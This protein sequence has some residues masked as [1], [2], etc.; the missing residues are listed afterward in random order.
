MKKI[1]VTFS[2][3]VLL[4]CTDENYAELNQ[5][6]KSPTE[7]PGSFLF[8]GATKSLFDQMG[9]TSVN[10]NVFRLFAQHWTET[11]Y[12]TETNYNIKNRDIPG[13]HW[14]EMYNDVL[15]DLKKAKETI[16]SDQ[17]LLPQ[18]KSNQL[19]IL[20]ILEIY[21]WQQLVDTFGNIPYTEALQGVENKTPKYDDAAT[22]YSDLL[23]RIAAAHGQLNTS[24][25]GFDNDFI[26]NN[27]IAKWKKIAASLRFKIAMRIADA[28]ATLSKSHA[29]AAFADGLIASNADN[30]TLSY[31]ANT[32]NAHPLYADLVMSGRQDF[33]PADTFV[34]YLNNL[35]DPRRAVFFDDNKTPYVGG[36]YGDFNN[37]AN[38]TH[39]GD[40]FFTPDLTGNIMDFS[41]ISF[42]LA[43]AK[44]RGYNV[45]L[46]AA[47]YYQQAVTASME[48]WG[49]D[50][51]DITTYLNRPD[52]AYASAPGSWKEKIGKQFWIAMYN[53]GFEAWSVWRKYDAPALQL[54]V[55]TGNPVP[56]RFTYPLDETILNS[57]NVNAAASAIG[58]D[59]QQTKL[60]WDKF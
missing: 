20:S 18:K 23:T 43:E 19:A 30:F 42:L 7:V 17:S 58:G 28:D 57:T 39:I 55:A 15:Y 45:P 48:Y 49:V 6:P 13:F 16:E 25:Q 36:V 51:A 31:E 32:T 3:L 2:A 35:E 52:V 60:F 10:R 9:S 24:A 41:E 47:D 29:E 8:T 44:E 54:P 27:N 46:S 50:A 1:L 59:E 38:F 12:I 53:R 5:D 11:Q 22:I 14:T 34:N 21:T 26:F 37:Y 33:V 40:V 4:A 56:K